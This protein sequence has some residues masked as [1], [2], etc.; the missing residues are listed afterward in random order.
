VLLLAGSPAI[1]NGDATVTLTGAGYAAGATVSLRGVSCTNVHIVTNTSLTCTTGAHVAGAVDV[2][3][4]VGSQSG[5]LPGGYT[6]AMVAPLPEVKLPG[7]AS[8]SPGPLPGRRPAGP[9]SGPTLN[10]LAVVR[11]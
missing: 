9:P 11:P 7:T 5:T 4:T 6:Y 1:G 3:V 10:L 2:V 8:G